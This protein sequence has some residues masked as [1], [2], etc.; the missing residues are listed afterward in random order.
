MGD[1]TT[2]T[3]ARDD[4]RHERGADGDDKCTEEQGASATATAA[5]IYIYIY[6]YIYVP[7]HIA[8]VVSTNIVEEDEDGNCITY[9]RKYK[10][11]TLKQK[12]SLFA[13]LRLSHS[14]SREK[15][16]NQRE[17]KDKGNSGHDRLH[18]HGH[19]CRRSSFLLKIAIMLPLL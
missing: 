15:K 2:A 10:T 16:I 7:V 6:I 11:Y 12:Q 17:A 5:V 19:R 18:S 13:L 3:T 14:R 4:G 9:G 8:V 1:A